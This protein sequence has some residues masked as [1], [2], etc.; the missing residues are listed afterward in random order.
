MS[1]ASAEVFVDGAYVGTVQDFWADLPPLMIVP[2][3]HR[4]ELR[5]AGY[6]TVTLDVTTTAGQ[7]IPYA[8]E[9]QP[10]RAY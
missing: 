6:R 9:L 5:A 4:I 8:G 10:L 7:V 3:S 2:G 1:P